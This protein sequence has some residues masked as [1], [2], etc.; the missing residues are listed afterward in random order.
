VTTRNGNC[1]YKPCGKYLGS[2][3]YKGLIESS[4]ELI[5]LL[6]FDNRD[7]SFGWSGAEAAAVIGIHHTDLWWNMAT[8]VAGQ[9][10]TQD[11]HLCAHC[12]QR[13]RDHPLPD[14]PHK[15]L[16]GLC[17]ACRYLRSEH[18]RRWKAKAAIGEHVHHLAAEWARGEDVESDEVSDPFL[19]GLEDWYKTYEP[20]FIEVE[21]TVYYK[22]G[23][24]EYVGTFDLLAEHNCTCPLADE[25]CRCLSLMD[26]KT[27]DFKADKD[28]L[29]QLSSYRYAQKLTRWDEGKQTV[30][31]AMPTVSHT[32]V[33]WLRPTGLAQ[34]VE[35]HT[36]NETFN[37][38]LRLIDLHTWEKGVEKDLKEQAEAKAMDEFMTAVET[39]TEE[40][41]NAEV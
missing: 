38:F 4:T 30:L 9:P 28:W 25:R 2:R 10:C 18:D 5:K 13:D 6:N 21:Q 12:R 17:P 33:L 1:E 27:G 11:H 19:D 7:R 32:Y 35:V 41:A 39:M 23:P 3:P 14:D 34:M 20:T 40:D 36:T 26:I 16:S 8:T 37:T 22:A 29:L 24:R 15:F 31:R